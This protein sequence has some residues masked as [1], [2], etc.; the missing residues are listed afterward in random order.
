MHSP[1]IVMNKIGHISK[2]K[3]IN[4]PYLQNKSNKYVL[5]IGHELRVQVKSSIEMLQHVWPG[6]WVWLGEE[7]NEV[8]PMSSGRYREQIVPF[9]SLNWLKYFPPSRWDIFQI[10]SP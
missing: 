8:V 4:W 1:Y 2:T 5:L 9:F 6:E 10:M 3:A 7:C